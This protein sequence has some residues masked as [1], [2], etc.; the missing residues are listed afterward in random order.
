[1]ELRQ[2]SY[3][4]AVAEERH[5]PRA[6]KRV[7]IAQP[8][9]SQQIRRLEAELGESLFV[10][11]RRAV[12]LTAAGEALLPHAR[13]ALAA[14]AGGREAVRALTGLLAGRLALGVVQPLPDRRL[15]LLVGDFRRRHP[16]VELAL[17]EDE[18]EPLT[19][20]VSA[21]RLDVA[22]IALG[23]YDCPPPGLETR[24]VASEP[25]VVAVHP[26]HP[27]AARAAV[28]LRALRDEPMVT[29]LRGSRL[30]NTL[31]VACRS[32]GFAPRVVAET[33][34]L[35]LLVEL[36]AERVGVAVLPASETAGATGIA[37]L[38]LLRPK[39]ER[40]IM[41]AWRPAGTPP[42]ARAFLALAAERL[43]TEAAPR[44]SGAA[45]PAASP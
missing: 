26:E 34:D 1:M 8:A 11:D 13:A 42:A 2:L 37:T 19:A 4:V 16:Q 28:A 18:P 29:L 35:G 41:L 31:E 3:F 27:L 6:A 43:G 20:A 30:R 45:A 25:V 39:L 9:V 5:F 12:T 15:P 23:R 40:R 14:A 33:S 10:R 21:G 36:A 17:I 38:P 22:V 7:T 44:V 24:L 32:A